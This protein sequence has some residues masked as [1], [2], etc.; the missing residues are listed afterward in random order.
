MSKLSEYSKFDNLK[1]DDDS[2]DEAEQQP[3][4][5]PTEVAAP[6]PTGAVM[7]KNEQNGRFIFEYNGNPIYEWEQALEEVT[8]YIRPPKHIQKGN[9]IKI[10]IKPQHLKV[11]LVEGTTWFINEPTGGLVDVDESTWSL[12]DND[13]ADGINKLIVIYLTKAQKGAA[14]DAALQGQATSSQTLDP[15]AKEQVK[16]DLMLERFQQ[17]HPG[18]DFRD[19]TFNGAVPDARTFMGGVQYQ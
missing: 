9:E 3:A 13:D 7:R 12:E 14:W 4:A 16:K 19:A 18:F 2:S 17:E 1:E 10:E 15:V 8:I 11:G 6:A 5:Q